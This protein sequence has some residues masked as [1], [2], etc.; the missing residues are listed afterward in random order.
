MATANKNALNFHGAD[1]RNT[2]AL[3][4]PVLIYLIMVV[5]PF[6]IHAGPVALSGVRAFLLIM[7]VPTLIKLFSGKYGRL[8]AADFLFLMHMG[9]AGVALVANNPDRMIQFV[10]S[11]AVEFLGGYVLAR[12]YIRSPEAMIA[13]WKTLFAIIIFTLPLAM[14]ESVTA[15]PIAA[16]ILGKIP[17]IQGLA[18]IV[19]EPRMGLN[20]AQVVFSHPIHYGLFGSVIFALCVIGMKQEWSNFRRLLTT[21]LI[22]CG[23]F[24]SLSSGA[25]LP[26]ALQIGLMIWAAVFRKLKARWVLLVSLIVLA[27]VVIDLASN[28]PPIRVFM[29]YATFSPHNAYWRGLIFEYGIQNVWSNP[30]FG[31]GLND[32]VRP[33]WMH[34]STVDN[35]WLLITMQF[36]IPGFILLLCGYFEILIRIGRAK[37]D[38][39]PVKWRLRRAYMFSFVGLTLTLCT[40]HVWGNIYSFTFFL[41]GSGV[42]MIFATA[43]APSQVPEADPTPASRGPLLARPPSAETMLVR[44]PVPTKTSAGLSRPKDIVE[45]ERG[46]RVRFTRFPNQKKTDRRH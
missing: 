7:I 29:S 1:K 36:G 13:V 11:I 27:Y 43:D 6:N 5:M 40:V 31:I 32:W 45:K 4:L 14:F 9:W 19:M 23:V 12:V 22:C 17:G 21:G 39:D 42:W 10:G 46:D 3:P 35:F 16:E 41:L 18:K 20:R 2:K 26:V 44:D 30:L 25:L 24:F 8:V 15:R 34:T 33:A 28:R 37:L 38:A